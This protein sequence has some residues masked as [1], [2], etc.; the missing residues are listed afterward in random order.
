MSVQFKNTLASAQIK[1]Q[2]VM[3]LAEAVGN[4]LL[5]VVAHA[6]SA[7]FMQTPTRRLWLAMPLQDAVHIVKYLFARLTGVFPHLQRVVVPFEMD[8]NLGRAKNISLLRIDVDKILVR[9][10]GWR[11]RREVDRRGITPLD[12][13]LVTHAKTFD[14]LRVVRKYVAAAAGIEW[15][16]PE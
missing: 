13:R 14:T 9:P 3:R 6:A 15:S 8:A 4:E 10:L 2:H 5:R 12:L 16:N 7:R 1:I 11:L